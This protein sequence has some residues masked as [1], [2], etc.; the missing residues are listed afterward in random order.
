MTRVFLHQQGRMHDFSFTL[1]DCIAFNLPENI[2]ALAPSTESRSPHPRSLSTPSLPVSRLPSPVSRLPFPF[3]PAMQVHDARLSS[4]SPILRLKSRTKTAF[5]LTP[6]THRHLTPI[7]LAEAGFYHSST[8]SN[9]ATPDT[10]RCFLC[11]VQLG[12]WDPEDDPFEEHLKRGGCA[13]A[14]V[15]CW[16]KVDGRRNPVEG[17]RKRCVE[18]V[19]ADSMG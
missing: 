15:V 3:R 2:T 18:A 13:W 5:P 6:T 16:L 14:D 19:E 12:G 8:Q 9:A 11:D 4:F 1:H 7:N 10:C 17:G